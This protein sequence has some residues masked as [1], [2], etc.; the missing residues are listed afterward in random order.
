[1]EI[2]HDLPQR[3][4]L[5]PARLTSPVRIQQLQGPLQQVPCPLAR[6][7]LPGVQWG[8][9]CVSCGSLRLQTTM[10]NCCSG[11]AKPAKDTAAAKGQVRE[12]ARI[13]RAVSSRGNRGGGRTPT[14]SGA[15]AGSDCLC[16][17]GILSPWRTVVSVAD[18]DR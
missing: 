1:M 3:A 12:R 5:A 10:G 11:E 2:S 15:Y 4:R 7:A 14:P 13:G 18:A 16:R 9:S 8:S 6:C 17:S